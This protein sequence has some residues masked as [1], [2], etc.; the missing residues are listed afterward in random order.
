M[1]SLNG[2]SLRILIEVL[3]EKI[4][5]MKTEM[6][7]LDDDDDNLSDLEDELMGLSNVATELK[8]CYEEELKGTGNLPPYAELVKKR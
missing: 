3:N 2:I 1:S 8:A 6:D 4:W 7:K 5:S